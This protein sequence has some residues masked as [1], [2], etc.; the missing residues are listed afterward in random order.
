MLA[1]TAQP[2][3]KEPVR[4]RKITLVTVLVVKNEMFLCGIVNCNQFLSV[5]PKF[6]IGT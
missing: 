6:T 1:K 4:Q 2:F 5:S 3:Y